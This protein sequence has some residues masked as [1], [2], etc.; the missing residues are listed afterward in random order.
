M[1]LKKLF[2]F[3]S[4]LMFSISFAACSSDDNGTDDGEEEPP[5]NTGK[6]LILINGDNRG[7]FEL[8]DA[9][10]TTAVG[11][12]D[13]IVSFNHSTIPVQSCS[14][15]FG[16]AFNNNVLNLPSGTDVTKVMVRVSNIIYHNKGQIE[17]AGRYNGGDWQDSKQRSVYFESGNVIIIH[18][19]GKTY[20]E[21]KDFT[22]TS[23]MRTGQKRED[24]QY[25]VNC[26]TPAIDIADGW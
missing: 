3:L 26:V 4:V 13:L 16:I 19:D 24:Y 22:F 10:Y 6:D 9:Y 21:F 18:K 20:F 14:L 2:Y 8:T 7:G 17:D 25:I 12:T 23:T 11:G 15:L 1:N 5:V